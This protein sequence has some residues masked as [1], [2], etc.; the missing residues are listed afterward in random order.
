MNSPSFRTLLALVLAAYGCGS[1]PAQYPPGSYP[2]PATGSSQPGATTLPASAGSNPAQAQMDSQRRWAYAMESAQKGAFLGGIL[3]GPFGAPAS[4]GLG[5]VGFLYGMASADAKIAEENA[6]AQAQ[7]Q[8]ESTKDQQLETAIEQELERQR[9]LDNQIVSANPSSVSP[10]SSSAADRIIQTQPA[11]Q[12]SPP[13]SKPVEK[14][15]VA[16]LGQSAAMPQ[17]AAPFKNVEVRDT[18]GDG[19]PDLWIYYNPQK[20][21]EIVRQE[22][23][24]KGDS[25]VDTWS[26]FKDGKLVRREVDSKNQGQPD[27]FY[28]YDNEKIAREERDQTGQGRVSYRGFYQNGR[29]AKVEEDTTDHGRPDRWIY[30]D[31]TKDGE[32]V[33]KE[34]RDLNGDG[35]VDLWTYFENGRMVRRDLSATGLQLLTEQ[36]KLPAPAANIRPI[37][38]SGS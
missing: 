34:E 8:K 27:T 14:T 21:G 15:Q 29:L 10:R 23:A 2:Y 12:T 20:P 4:M 35:A 26:Y 33:L 37:I 38:A 18:N 19:V 30:Y 6:L 25:N 28:Y 13:Q 1:A 24:T 22:E 32:V 16:S 5:L 3:G 36:D 31:T 7:Y 9:T 11:P 17:P